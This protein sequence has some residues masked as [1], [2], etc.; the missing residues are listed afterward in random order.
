VKKLVSIAFILLFSLAS[1]G[2]Q[3]L[4]HTCGGETTVEVMPT[5]A[6]DP[7]GCGDESPASRCCTTQLKTFHLDEMQQGS[8]VSLTN[9]ETVTIAELPALQGLVFDQEAVHIPSVTASPPSFVSPTILFCTFL[10]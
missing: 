7:C 3:I 2:F 4:V 8:T 1:G 5:S 9:V 6:Q 10:I